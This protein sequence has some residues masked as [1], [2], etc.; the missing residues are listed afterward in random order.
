M[1][2]QAQQMINEIEEIKDR[3]ISMETALIESEEAETED[4]EAIKVA[5]KEYKEGKTIRHA[6]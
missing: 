2:L 6:H 3:L 1:A 4:I 5:L